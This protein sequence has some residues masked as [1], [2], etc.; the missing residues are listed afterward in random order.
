MPAD[1][2]SLHPTE[3]LELLN[4]VYLKIIKSKEIMKGELLGCS[5]IL[6]YFSL[7]KN[8]GKDDLEKVLKTFFFG[9]K[10]YDGGGTISNICK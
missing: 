1:R 3:G 9:I 6:G 7:D 10:S 2:Q 4:I 8:G 5:K